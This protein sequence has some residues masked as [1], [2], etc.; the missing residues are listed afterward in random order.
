MST[1]GGTK[2]KYVQ[3]WFVEIKSEQISKSDTS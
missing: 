3:K 2:F 1:V